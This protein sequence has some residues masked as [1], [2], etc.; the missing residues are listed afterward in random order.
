MFA[1]H[2][3][4][5]NPWHPSGSPEPSPGICPECR[6]GSKSWAPLGVARNQRTQT[7]TRQEATRGQPHQGGFCVNT[8]GGADTQETWP[9]T[10]PAVSILGTVRN[11]TGRSTRFRHDSHGNR[12][13]RGYQA[14]LG[15]PGPCRGT[16]SRTGQRLAVSLQTRATSPSDPANTGLTLKTHLCSIL[17]QFPHTSQRAVALHD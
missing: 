11:E 1:L 12:G 2:G 15:P 4:R 7:R 10:W 5:F 17:P 3:A 6:A 16:G 14:G 8:E 13:E 9:A